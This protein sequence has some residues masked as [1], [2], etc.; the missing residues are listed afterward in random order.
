MRY[1]LIIY[2]LLLTLMAALAAITPAR[3]QG[4]EYWVATTGSNSNPGTSTQPWATLDYASARVLALHGSNCTVWFKDGVYTGSASLEERFATPITFKAVTPYRAVLQ[5][6]GTVLDLNGAK[7]IVLDGFE[8]R[9]ASPS[10]GPIVVYVARSGNDWAENITFRNNIFHDSYNNDLLKILDGSRYIT[11]ENNVFYNQAESEQLIDV[12][13]VTDVT[14]Q[15]NIFF[16]D[17]AG[18]G[19]VNGNDTKHYI[20][21]KDSNEGEDGLLGSDRIHV[22]RN[23]FLNWEG[24][25]EF[26]VQVG[27][28][29]KSFY[30]AK[31][32]NVENNLLIGNS[33]HEMSA[34]FGVAGAMNVTF[35]N[36]TIVGNLP[37]SSF[38]FRIVLKGSNPVNQNIR[39]YNNIWSDPTRTMGDGQFSS[40]EPGEVS[41]LVLDNNLYWNGGASIPSGEQINPMTADGHRVVSNPGLNTDQSALILPRWNGFSFLSGTGSVRQEFERLVD[42]YAQLP[43][44]SPAIDKA[45]PNLAPA[46]D[47]LGHYRGTSAEIGAYEYNWVGAPTFRDVPYTHWAWRYIQAIYDAGITGGCGNAPLVY[48]PASPVTRA[49]MAIFLLKGIHGSAYTPPPA[50]GGLFGDVPRGHWAAAWIEQLADEGITSGCGSGNFCP[51]TIVTRDQMAI[52]L[53]RAKHGSSYTP[54]PASGAV[55]SDVSAGYWAAPWIERLAAEGITGGCTATQYCPASQVTRDQMAVFLQRT[56]SLP[57][58]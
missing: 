43:Y 7:N 3:A 53:L 52:F 56:F 33:P 28:D 6:N 18:S 39:F 20:V 5:S 2:T 27:N 36:N 57:L 13:S 15:D 31:N 4:C 44:G 41:G 1:R 42:L 8:I 23:I 26:F 14:I 38:G 21:I 12:N 11:V 46:D 50:S 58:P 54:P 55:F 45:N 22:R 32:V 24:G 40:G 47:I 49:Q 34:P 30:E 16:N 51:D 35:A 37:S 17:F 25:S 9:H 10:A 19:R 29:G 48:C